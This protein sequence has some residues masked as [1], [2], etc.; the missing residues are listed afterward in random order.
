MQIDSMES[1]L[2]TLEAARIEKVFRTGTIAPCRDE[3]PRCL[4]VVEA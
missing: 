3:I 4:L 1:L 2:A